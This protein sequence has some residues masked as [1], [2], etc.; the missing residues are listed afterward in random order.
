MNI[1]IV[2]PSRESKGG[3]AQM[4]CAL[5]DALAFKHNITFIESYKDGNKISK[6]CYFIASLLHFM[7][8]V[9]MKDINIVHINTSSGRSFQRK[10]VFVT[11]CKFFN[12][13][14]VIHIHSGAFIDY[15]FSLSKVG[16]SDMKSVLT[17]AASVVAISEHFYLTLKDLFPTICIQLIP[18]TTTIQ[19]LKYVDIES[20]FKN[21][22]I[23]YM[24]RISKDK[25]FLDACKIYREL[26]KK[27]KNLKFVVAGVAEDSSIYENEEFLA[28]R[29]KVE[30]MGWVSGD[31]RL[32]ILTEATVVVCPSYF[33]AFGLSALEASM[34]G[35]PTF[36]YNVGGVP[37]VI[38][39][40]ENGGLAVIG[41][42]LCLTKKIQLLLNSFTTYSETSKNCILFSETK[43][44]QSVF[45]DRMLKLYREILNEGN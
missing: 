11:I 41:E 21:R 1:L 27:I 23:L 14:Y 39:D 44:S 34:T 40:E 10:K 42:W 28:I 24:G 26:N 13:P 25:G 31:Y 9:L 35:T 32:D 5:E 29:D 19:P 8:C 45:K 43:F 6:L 12:I 3:I 4:M 17:D 16:K 22:T 7:C 2:G 36:A 20:K 38:V 30:F 15:Y 37:D 18:N 33:E